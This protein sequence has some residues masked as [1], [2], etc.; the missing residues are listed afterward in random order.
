MLVERLFPDKTAAEGQLFAARH[1]GELKRIQDFVE[2]PARNGARTIREHDDGETFLRKARDEVAKP[3][4]RSAVR[5]ALQA[6]IGVQLPAEAVIR[7][8]A[9][10]QFSR[11]EGLAEH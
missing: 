9:I 7:L 5:H 6:T 4:G 8:A 2:H 1:G 3:D 11:R 10:V